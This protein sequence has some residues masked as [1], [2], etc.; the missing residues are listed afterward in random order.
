[1]IRQRGP[2]LFSY[3]APR[4]YSVPKMTWPLNHSSATHRPITKK[5]RRVILRK[6]R[7]RKQSPLPWRLPK[8]QSMD[9]RMWED[10]RIFKAAGLLNVWFDLYRDVLNLKPQPTQAAP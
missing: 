5:A 6:T 4:V 1:M 2:P 7:P 9:A 3:S 8:P 10:Y